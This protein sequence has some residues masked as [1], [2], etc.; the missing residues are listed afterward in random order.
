VS[1]PAS[2]WIF[3]IPARRADPV[4]CSCKLLLLRM[5]GCVD[6]SHQGPASERQCYPSIAWLAEQTGQTPAAVRDQLAKLIA[7]G[8]IRRA[9]RG[10]ELAWM[11]PTLLQSPKPATQVAPLKSRKPA[12]QVAPTA[13]QVAR[14]SD[15]GSTNQRKTNQEPIRDQGDLLDL[16][17]TATA[18]K[19]SN[20][21]PIMAALLAHPVSKPKMRNSRWVGY[22]LERIAE[23]RYTAADVAALLDAWGLDVSAPD[24]HRLWW[25][26]SDWWRDRVVHPTRPRGARAGPKPKRFTDCARAT[27]IDPRPNPFARQ[28]HQ[29]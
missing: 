17:P 12:T 1:H 4:D 14:T 24:L 18:T 10:F 23:D 8:W 13:T 15:S 19:R 3:R 21:D 16:G 2:A 7:A 29:T 28:D 26:D 25:S 11:E 9:G 20:D 6:Y 5:W 27:D 22:A